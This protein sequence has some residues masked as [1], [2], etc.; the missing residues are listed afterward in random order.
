MSNRPQHRRTRN[1]NV[2]VAHHAAV[3]YVSA[4]IVGNSNLVA[5][6]LKVFEETDQPITDEVD[7]GRPGEIDVTEDNGEIGDAVEH[8]TFV[9][10][11]PGRVALLAID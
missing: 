2:K 10:D 11:E 3:H 1:E 7:L 9:G 6:L 5:G 4:F 8:H